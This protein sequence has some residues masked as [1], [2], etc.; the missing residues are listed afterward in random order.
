M[1]LNIRRIRREKDITQAALSVKS[2][3]SR[4]RISS[5]EQGTANDTTASTLVKIADALG[6]SVSDLFLD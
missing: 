5:L 1:R 2:G 4:A 3:V 6:V